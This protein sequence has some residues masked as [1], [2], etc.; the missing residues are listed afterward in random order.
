M[1]L[2]RRSPVGRERVRHV[3]RYPLFFN[4]GN[5]V[6]GQGFIAQVAIEGRVL[7]ERTEDAFY[8]ALGVNPGSAVGHGTTQSEA[9]HALLEDI[10]LVIF[11]I[12]AE[13]ASFED[14]AAEV[15]AYV[16]ETNSRDQA[17]WDEA[18][19]LVRAG[20]IDTDS[21]PTRKPGETAA[22][23]YVNLVQP[24]REQQMSSLALTPALND[25]A[26]RQIAA[27]A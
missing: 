17:E 3:T 27:V 26:E 23:V 21:F 1:S 25:V 4:H 11:E 8:T 7:L 20:K 18:V 24:R 10:K 13:V 15:R 9:M 22:A 6:A 19:R 2:R 12:S 5:L 14:F 16:L